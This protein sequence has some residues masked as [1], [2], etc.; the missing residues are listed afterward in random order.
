MLEF[1]QIVTPY[2]YCYL[3]F[4]FIM[5]KLEQQVQLSQRENKQPKVEDERQ[6]H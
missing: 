6:I 2:T 1:L 4:H 5:P 3:M